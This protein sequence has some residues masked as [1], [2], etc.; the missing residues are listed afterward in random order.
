LIGIV[1]SYIFL[2]REKPRY[3]TG[4]GTSLA[5]AVSGICAAM[6]VEYCYWRH[7]KKYENM[8]EEEINDKYSSAELEKMGDRSPLFK[9][10][11]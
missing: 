1:G 9:Y 7:N 4:F 3:P 10:G 11:L 6:T 2:E 8:T 5:F